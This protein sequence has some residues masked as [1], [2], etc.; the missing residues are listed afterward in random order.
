[1]IYQGQAANEGYSQSLTVGFVI[2]RPMDFSLMNV[3]VVLC[4][5]YNNVLDIL[6]IYLIVL[7]MYVYVYIYLYIPL[8]NDVINFYYVIFFSSGYLSKV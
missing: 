6:K 4:Y 5:H 1:M 2:P 7:Y 3:S 8:L